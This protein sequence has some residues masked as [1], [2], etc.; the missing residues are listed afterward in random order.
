MSGEAQINVVPD[1]VV[2]TLGVETSN[3][4]LQTAKSLNDDKVKQVI[5]AAEALGVPA[6][7][8]QTDHISIEPRYRENYE[9]RDFVGYFVRQTVVVTLKD[10]SRFED[11]LTAVLEAGANYVHGSP[12][13]HDGAAKVPG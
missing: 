11:L 12:I 13:Q 4:Q 2:L 5:A 8:I 1:E 10:I 3:K 6:K 7:H 9:Q